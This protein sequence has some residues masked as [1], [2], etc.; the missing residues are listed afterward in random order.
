MRVT[1]IEILAL[2]LLSATA[3]TESSNVT[4]TPDA[5]SIAD[6]VEG[7][8]GD[9]AA[10][11]PPADAVS[12]EAAAADPADC[13]RCPERIKASAPSGRRLCRQNGPPSSYT[14][15]FDLL[16]CV[17]TA[18]ACATAC[19][20]LCQDSQDFDTACMNCAEAECAA[21]FAACDADE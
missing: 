16:T 18:P 21:Q 15:T 11:T 7:P 10:E 3:C 4:T 20:A 8:T 2:A 14:R 5:A 12:D 1:G 6:A 17:C 19:T 13:E 9:T